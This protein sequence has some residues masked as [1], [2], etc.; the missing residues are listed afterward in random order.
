LLQEGA[1]LDDSELDQLS[2]IDSVLPDVISSRHSLISGKII[3]P[4][5]PITN[6]L[7]H[8]SDDGYQHVNSVPHGESMEFDGPLIDVGNQKALVLKGHGSEV[9]VLH[10]DTLYF[11]ATNCTCMYWLASIT[12][13]G[14]MFS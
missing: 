6:E 13:N 3:K 11:T 12:S 8:V 2:L 4:E 5:I 14:K 7:M 1:L 10:Q 9:C